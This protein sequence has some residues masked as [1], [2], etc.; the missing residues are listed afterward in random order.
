MS[1]L[2][3]LLRLSAIQSEMMRLAEHL[4]PE[5]GKIVRYAARV[6]NLL[7]MIRQPV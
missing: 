5:A 4:G 7:R 1:Q 3:I 2:E 6:L